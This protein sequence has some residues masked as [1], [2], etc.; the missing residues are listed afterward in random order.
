MTYNIWVELGCIHWCFHFEGKENLL[1]RYRFFSCPYR[2][3]SYINNS[4]QQHQEK[5]IR[6]SSSSVSSVPFFYLTLCQAGSNFFWFFLFSFSSFT[7]F[8]QFCSRQSLAVWQFY[9][10]PL[11][12]ITTRWNHCLKVGS[13]WD[14][15]CMLMTAWWAGGGGAMCQ[16]ELHNRQFSLSG[17][18]SPS[19]HFTLYS[20][21]SKVTNCIY[22]IQI[23]V[24]FLCAGME[25]YL[26]RNECDN[27]RG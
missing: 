2:L 1:P 6:W 27:V 17:G 12:R 22:F 16:C 24:Y 7:A 8:L 13:Q 26:K 5:K 15:A 14:M 20:G 19:N 3:V 23:F 21:D 18:R 11:L 10:S 9:C 4:Q 25:L